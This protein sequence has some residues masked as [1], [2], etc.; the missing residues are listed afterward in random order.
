VAGGDMEGWIKLSRCLLDKPLFQNEKL[1][2][3]WIWCLLKATH[4]GYE[5]LIGLQKITLLQG[6]FIFGRKKAAEEL[7]LPES[8]VWR[9]MQVLANKNNPSLEI[10]THTKYS[11]VNIINWSGYQLEKDEKMDTCE[12]SNNNGL[13]VVA[14]QQVNNKWTTSEQQMDTNKN[15]KN[16]KND[17]KNI[18]GEFGKVLLTEK[19]YEKLVADYGVEMVVKII[20]TLDEY[21]EEKGY[22]SKSHNLAIRRWVVDAVKKKQPQQQIQQPKQSVADKAKEAA[23]RYATRHG[24]ETSNSNERSISIIEE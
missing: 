15:V 19:E 17:K 13:E 24:F 10:E 8:T 11:I 3:I 7:S 14:G 4:K 5:Q 16:V 1:L 9:L 12:T 18:Y 6:Q 21:I 2:K 20:K 22:K 23:E